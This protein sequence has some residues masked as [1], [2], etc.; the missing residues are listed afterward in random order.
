MN[1]NDSER[2][3]GLLESLGFA[4]QSEARGADLVIY[5]TCS[6][7]ATAEDR[8]FGLG[9]KFAQYK[10]EKPDMLVAITGCMPGRDGRGVMRAKLPW[11][12]F[13]FPIKD[14]VSLPFLINSSRPDIANTGDELKDY[15]QIEP[16][17]AGNR[18]QAFISISKGCDNYCTYCV[19][20]Y[21]RGRM[22]SRLL[23]DVIAEIKKAVDD[24]AV[25]ITLLGQNVNTYQPA[26]LE[27][28]SPANPYQDG[29]AVL[30]WE[31][32]HLNGLIRIHFTAPNPQDMSDEV[33][34]ALK[35]PRQVNYL[36]LPVQSGSNRILRKMNRRYT[37]EQYLE[38]IEKVKKI[39]PNISLGTDIILGFCSETENDF[40]ETVDLYKQVK[41]D[42][43]YHAMYS[44]RSG[45]VAAKVWVDDVPKYEKKRRWDYIQQ[46]MEEQTLNKNQAYLGKTVE[47]L[48][49]GVR[50]R[51]V[52]GA[53][54]GVVCW[55][56]SR[57]M[58][59]V[60]FAG[61]RSLVGSIIKVKIYEALTWVLRG[62]L[63]IANSK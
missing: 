55:G 35:L 29:F 6:V 32:N 44:P 38:I 23:T 9:E 16:T 3:V 21:A 58:K 24:G 26:D 48:V 15:F 34:D 19:V 8:I 12:D 7:R 51:G 61:D 45:T 57:E 10:K 1:K 31:V 41:F 36:H 46:V 49:E 22:E 47:V 42:I 28:K 2:I 30:L 63:L 53:G 54:G 17:R 50:G 39:R 20:P 43:S 25:E 33:I 56:N 52:G 37:R 62:K 13:Y 59:I 4:A 18:S 40:L 14:L 11:V 27:T 5:N 60:E